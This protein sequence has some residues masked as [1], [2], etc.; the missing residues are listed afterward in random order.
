MQLEFA[1]IHEIHLLNS[2]G[3]PAQLYKC[4]YNEMTFHYPSFENLMKNDMKDHTQ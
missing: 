1:Y 2:T 3:S 4:C